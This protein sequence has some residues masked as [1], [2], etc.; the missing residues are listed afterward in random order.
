[1]KL[2][3]SKRSIKDTLELAAKNGEH[4]LTRSL[5]RMIGKTTALIEFAKEHNYI[6]TVN[7]EAIANGLRSDFD[8]KHIVGIDRINELNI[9][10]GCSKEIVFDECCNPERIKQLVNQGFKVVTGFIGEGH[11]QNKK[12]YYSA[13]C[14]VCGYKDK[15]QHES[16]KDYKEITVCPK[17]NGAFID[18]FKLGKYKQLDNTKRNEEPLLQIVQSDINSVPVVH[19]KGQQIDKNIRISFDWKT[20]DLNSMSSSYIHIEHV[21]PEEKHFNTKT[22]QHNHPISEKENVR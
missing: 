20:G 9:L 4:I 15:V 8:Y 12:Y 2:D 19:Y 14:L 5:Q 3:L 1:M 7:H 18:M 10:D 21:E 22:I 16:K 13:A 17:C 6:V 11:V